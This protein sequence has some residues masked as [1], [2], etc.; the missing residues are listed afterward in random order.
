MVTTI[1]ILLIMFGGMAGESDSMLAP[2]SL[3]AIGALLINIG[4]KRI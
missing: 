3:I 4:E 1:G 2:L